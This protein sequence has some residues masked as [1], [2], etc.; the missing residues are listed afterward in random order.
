MSQ[1]EG[2]VTVVP[3]DVQCPT[4]GSWWSHNIMS[5][6]LTYAYVQNFLGFPEQYRCDFFCPL[7]LRLEVVD[8]AFMSSHYALRKPSPFALYQQ[9]G[10]WLASTH[11]QFR[12]RLS[13]HPHFVELQH[14]MDGMVSWTMAGVQKDSPFLYCK[15]RFLP[16]DV[17]CLHTFKIFSWLTLIHMKRTDS[18]FRAPVSFQTPRWDVSMFV[19]KEC[20]ILLI[21]GFWQRMSLPLISDSSHWYMCRPFISMQ[22]KTHQVCS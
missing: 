12:S 14:V 18:L 17:F 5:T 4:S 3:M 20:L 10:Y 8:P 6:F 22:N 15:A 11:L 21:G 13:G 7:H 19:P 9:K 16:F 1:Y 2:P